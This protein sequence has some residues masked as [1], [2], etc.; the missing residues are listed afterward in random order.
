MIDSRKKRAALE[1]DVDSTAAEADSNNNNGNVNGSTSLFDERQRQKSKPRP[2]KARLTA[3]QLEE[4]ARQQQAE[5]DRGWRRVIELL[6]PMRQGDST[7]E[8]DWLVEA[9]RLIEVF[10]QSKDLFSTA[11]VSRIVWFG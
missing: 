7:A 6:A 5:M 9:E 11:K 3:T 8:S 1:P 2:T 10:R 4:L